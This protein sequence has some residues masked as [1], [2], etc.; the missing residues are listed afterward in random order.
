MYFLSF[1]NISSSMEDNLE[2]IK[3][4]TRNEEMNRIILVRW[5]TMCKPKEKGGLGVKKIFDLYK[6]IIT[7]IG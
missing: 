6:A 4:E 3:I 1:F 2:K 7:K 5:D